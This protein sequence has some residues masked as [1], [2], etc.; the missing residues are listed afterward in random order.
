MD[1][2]VVDVGCAIVFVIERRSV[3]LIIDDCNLSF[4]VVL[5]GGR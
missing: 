5:R 3:H 4:V 2:V 1:D